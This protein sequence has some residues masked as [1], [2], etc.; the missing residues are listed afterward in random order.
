M[1]SRDTSAKGQRAS[2]NSTGGST[3]E[4]VECDPAATLRALEAWMATREAIK[5]CA[6][7]E[8]TRGSR[9]PTS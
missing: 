9:W 8:R 1:R 2:S 4:H 5:A 7:R 3:R 6:N